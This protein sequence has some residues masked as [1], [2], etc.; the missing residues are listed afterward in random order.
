MGGGE[1]VGVGYKGQST[2]PPFENN[3]AHACVRL[4]VRLRRSKVMKRDNLAAAILAQHPRGSVGV[5]R[6][7]RQY[8]MGTK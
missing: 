2:P 5:W 6:F 8:F 3:L 7:L 4:T 1:G